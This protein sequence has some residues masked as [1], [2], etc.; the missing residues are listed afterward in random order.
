MSSYPAQ[1]DLALHNI[2]HVRG[3]QKLLGND[4]DYLAT[5]IAYKLI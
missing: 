3:M 5:R 2:G 4:K 1:Q